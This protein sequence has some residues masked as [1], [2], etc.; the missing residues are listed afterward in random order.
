MRNKPWRRELRFYAFN[1]EL[2]TRYA[3]M[4]TERHV[5][6]VAVLTLHAEARSRLHL[7]LFGRDAWLAQTH[8]VRLA[9][10]A[11]DFLEIAHYPAP[12]VAGISLV[13]IE[14]H[15][16]T[17]AAGLFQGATCVGVQECRMGYRRDGA[18]ARLPAALHDRLQR[19]GITEDVQ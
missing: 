18:W 4:D 6:N 7:A 8:A 13:G 5:N 14:S 12:V 2:P 16:Y 3:D 10:V 17:L 11:T 19:F 15:R 1:T 9:G